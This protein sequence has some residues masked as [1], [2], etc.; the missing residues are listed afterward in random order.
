MT[1]P[2]VG[3]G[4]AL[5]VSNATSASSFV[6]IP[7]ISTVVTQEDFIAPI[8]LLLTAIQGVPRVIGSDGSAVTLA[9]YKCADGVAVGSGTLLHSG[10]YNMKGTA[11][12][13]QYLTLV[14]DVDSLTFNPGDRLGHV[15][16]GTATAAVGSVTATFE[17]VA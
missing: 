12:T 8:K 17:P 4:R 11:D 5:G 14:A 10:T 15:L 2:T 9:F 7:Y 6:T 13:N 1:A 16:A 3:T